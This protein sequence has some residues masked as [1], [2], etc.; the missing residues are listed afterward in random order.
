MAHYRG[1]MV[2]VLI[3]RASKRLLDRI[4]GLTLDV[5]DHSTT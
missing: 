1:R 3:M 4:G 2:G 5:G